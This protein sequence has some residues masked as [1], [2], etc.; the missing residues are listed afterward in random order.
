MRQSRESGPSKDKNPNRGRMPSRNM[1]F[2]LVELLVVIAVISLL[3]ALLIPVLRIA[4]EQAHR[5]VC[6]SNHRQ[7]TLAWIAYATEHDSKLASGRAF[8]NRGRGGGRGGRKS[9]NL[10]GW[11][12]HDFSPSAPN[13]PP[14]VPDPDKGALWPWIKDAEIYRC[15]RGGPGHAVTYATVVAVNGV[16]VEGTYMEDTGGW[17]L[18]TTGIHVGRTVLRLTKMTDIVSPGASQRAVFIDQGQTPTSS[19]FYVHYLYPRWSFRSPPPVQHGDGTTFSLA[20]GHAEYWKWKSRETVEMPRE[21]LFSRGVFSELLEGWDD[22]VPQ[23]QDGMYDLQ[24]LQRATW[25]RLGY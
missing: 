21:L 13:R 7:L 6:L 2:T 25:G 19:D 10:K 16:E 17:D 5:A 22:Y 1:A 18:T 12:G 9:A 4:R 20:D 11:V 3:M 23:T 24:R 14:W 8:G 15:R